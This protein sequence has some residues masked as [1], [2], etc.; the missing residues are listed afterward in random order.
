MEVEVRLYIWKAFRV[1]VSWMYRDTPNATK[2]NVCSQEFSFI[3]VLIESQIHVDA[4]Q[5][6]YNIVINLQLK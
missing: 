2:Q 5:N 4:W 6:Q 1:E 3:T